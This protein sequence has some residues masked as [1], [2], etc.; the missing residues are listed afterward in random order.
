MNV[1]GNRMGQ[2]AKEEIRTHNKFKGLLGCLL[3][4]QAPRKKP[5][6]QNK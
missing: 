4:A 5:A 1:I 2:K 6:P 3:T